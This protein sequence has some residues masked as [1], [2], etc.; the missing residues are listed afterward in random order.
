MTTNNI[1]NYGLVGAC[2]AIPKLLTYLCTRPDNF[3]APFSQL[4][5]RVASLQ[6]NVR[7]VAGE[8]VWFA[9]TDIVADNAWISALVVLCLT[10]QPFGS[11]ERGV[12]SLSA[13][14]GF[15]T[16]LYL[17]RLAIVRLCPQL[18]AQIGTRSHQ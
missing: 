3:S 11:F 9:A 4:R 10:K 15:C 14:A 18:R 2:Y 5:G 1:A 8:R 12:N 16:I 13:F 7:D 6:E 17:I